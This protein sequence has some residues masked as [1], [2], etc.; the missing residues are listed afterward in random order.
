MLLFV[1]ESFPAE[2]CSA[3]S[4][5]RTKQMMFFL[6]WKK[7]NDVVVVSCSKF[8]N[9]TCFD[10]YIAVAKCVNILRDQKIKQQK[11][12][13]LVA[14]SPS[15]NQVEFLYDLFDLSGDVYGLLDFIASVL[16]P[17]E[18][19]VSAIQIPYVKTVWGTLPTKSTVVV[20]MLRRYHSC[21]MLLPEKTARIF[22]GYDGCSFILF[23]IFFSIRL[24]EILTKLE[25]SQW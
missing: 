9:L 23:F 16:M 17:S 6:T 14:P 22:R 15:L 24:K 1:R 10:Q 3:I 7:L 5:N 12:F 21:L 25:S 19:D 18:D 13:G 2:K 8:S 20:A 4:A 11:A